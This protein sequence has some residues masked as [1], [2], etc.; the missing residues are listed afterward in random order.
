MKKLTKYEIQ[1]FYKYLHTFMKLSPFLY[2]WILNMILNGEITFNS[3][4]NKTLL[5]KAKM[6]NNNFGKF[7]LPINLFIYTY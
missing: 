7:S 4:I 2:K 6:R 5:L 1:N 3:Y